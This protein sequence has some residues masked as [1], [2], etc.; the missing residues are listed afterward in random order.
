MARTGPADEVSSGKRRTKL[1]SRRLRSAKRT[2]KRRADDYDLR[3]TSYEYS[4][5]EPDE[6]PWQVLSNSTTRG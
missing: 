5:C 4:C 3:S 2:R 1:G 6:G